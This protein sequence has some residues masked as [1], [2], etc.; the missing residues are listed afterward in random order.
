MSYSFA[1]T[2]ANLPRG[3]FARRGF[4]FGLALAGAGAIVACGSSGS[5]QSSNDSSAATAVARVSTGMNTLAGAAQA[6]NAT[7]VK[8]TDQN[9][10]DPATVTVPAGSTV[11]WVNDTTTPQSA[12]FDPTNAVNKGDVALPQGVSPFDSGLIQPGQVWSHSFTTPGTYR[13]VGIPSQAPGMK[14]TVV[15]TASNPATAG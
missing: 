12:T 4:L 15:V 7:V 2:S 14:G 8:M 10:L 11:T 13:Y 1:S 9:T 3:R 5:P 6:A